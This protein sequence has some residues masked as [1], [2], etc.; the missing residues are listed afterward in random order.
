MTVS[1]SGRH[2]VGAIV[3]LCTPSSGSWE[4]T[5]GDQAQTLWGVVVNPWSECQQTTFPPAFPSITAWYIPRVRYRRRIRGSSFP[6]GRNC[7]TL[8]RTTVT[9]KRTRSGEG[10]QS[11]PTKSELVLRRREGRDDRDFFGELSWHP[12]TALAT[13]R[14]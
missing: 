6:Q 1:S 9:C 5:R 4:V 13:V 10:D 8:P 14:T 2:G 3:K 12:P 7:T 11:N